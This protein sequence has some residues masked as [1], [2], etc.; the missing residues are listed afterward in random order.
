MNSILNQSNLEK[1]HALGKESNEDFNCWGGTLFILNKLSF[2][3][4]V[5]GSEIKQVLDDETTLTYDRKKGNILCLYL[6]DRI[7]Y[8]AVY[9]GADTLWHKKGSS[10][11]EYVTEEE[12]KQVYEH[13]KIEIRKLN[14]T[15]QLIN[16]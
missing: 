6:C 3:G 11:S 2:L 9:I 14:N 4:W 15:M 5:T 7:V 10:R 16:W 1:A 12:V 8:T 13:D